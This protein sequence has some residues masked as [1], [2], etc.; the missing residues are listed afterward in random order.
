MTTGAASLERPGVSIVLPCYNRGAYLADWL[1]SCAWWQPF[2]VPVEVLV[3]DD[4]GVDDTGAIAEWWRR[5]GLDVRYLRLRGRGSPRNNA[6]ARNAGIR[7]AHFPLV[8]N[9]DPDIVFVTD[10]VRLLLDR[11]RP[12]VFCSVGR[13]YPLTRTASREIRQCRVERSVGPSD[14]LAR[15]AGRQ[16]L[17]HR[18]DGVHGLHGAYLCDRA[19]LH[20]I[21]GYDERFR[22]WGWEDRDLLTRLEEGLGFQ[23]IYVPDAVVIHQWHPPLRADTETQND[24]DRAR[25]LWQMGWQQACASTLPSIR[26]NEDGWGNAPTSPSA[27]AGQERGS[28]R[29][30]AAGASAVDRQLHFDAY[31]H[32][33]PVWRRDGRPRTAMARLR[34]GLSRWWEQGSCEPPW[35]DD[36]CDPLPDATF[37]ARVA[38]A[39]AAGY[40]HARQLAL[41]YAAAA[42]E[43]SDRRAAEGA[44][45]AAARLPGPKAP[46]AHQRARWLIE[47]GQPEQAIDLLESALTADGI[48]AARAD[49]ESVDAMARLVE[50]L[51]SMGR[52]DRARVWLAA[53]SP[54]LGVFEDLL[55]AG[56]RARL[57]DSRDP[58][59][60]AWPPRVAGQAAGEFLFS[61]A[62]RAR[63][64]GLWM[65][66]QALFDA[67]LASG[68]TDDDELSARAAHLREEVARAWERAWLR[69]AERA[70]V[71][72]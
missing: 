3:V 19:A 15:A 51:V 18:P 16:N 7:A 58:D 36:D 71:A 55:F 57:L 13:Y 26:R 23:R 38:E 5:Q 1:A 9:S 69:A 53:A 44:L 61:V 30:G 41:G 47:D 35:G 50:L 34:V 27:S 46:V 12:G 52:D 25:T 24:R 33:A 43:A 72:P 67:Y 64:A 62:M 63:R 37:E 70:G 48:E 21:R 45:S 4:G 60:D 17:V 20:R 59:R 6:I 54:G 39:H 11:W 8:L 28:D 2:D 14:Y 10:V 56:Y 49:A 68:P 22:L 32:E 66:A 31:V 29:T 40:G 42:F 65:G